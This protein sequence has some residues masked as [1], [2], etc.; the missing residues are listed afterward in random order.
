MHD[1]KYKNDSILEQHIL[2]FL[3]EECFLSRIIEDCIYY[4]S[5][6]ANHFPLK[7]RNVEEFRIDFDEKSEALLIELKSVSDFLSK[8]QYDQDHLAAHI[9]AEEHKIIEYFNYNIK[10]AY[11]CTERYV[12]DS[13]SLAVTEDYMDNELLKGEL[14]FLSEVLIDLSTFVNQLYAWKQEQYKKMLLAGRIKDEVCLFKDNRH[15][16]AVRRN[17]SSAR[18]VFQNIQCSIN[19]IQ[20]YDN[21]DAVPVAMFQIRQAIE[22]RLWEIFGIATICDDNGNL[23]KLTAD[24]LLCIAGLDKSVNFHAKLSNI[25]LIHAWTNVY[26]HAG[27]SAFYWQIDFAYHYLADFIIMPAIMKD[28]YEDKLKEELEKNLCKGSYRIRYRE[29]MDLISESDERKRI[30][31]EKRIGIKQ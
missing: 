29:H 9:F 31:F 24:K 2:N 11:S 13:L 5:S 19:R 25:K 8:K 28:D 20:F 27:R 23:V 10:V 12:K 4:Y 6:D 16:C 26:V 18:D 3:N 1:K 30:E 22:L 21:V 15:P 17:R 7:K 14:A